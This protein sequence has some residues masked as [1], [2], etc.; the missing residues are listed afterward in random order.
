M[1][2]VIPAILE[3]DWNAIERKLN[4]VKSFAKT[5]HIDVIDGVFA[6]NKTLL[7]PQ[8][9]SVFKEDFIL[10]AHFM[11]DEPVDYLAPFAQAG[12]KRFLGHIERM[13]DQA[14][15]VARAEELGEVGLA[16]DGTTSLDKIEVS[17][18]D[19]DAVLIMTIQAGFSGQSFVAQ[20][21]EKVQK[22]SDQTPFPIEVDGGINEITIIQ[23]KNAGARRF[24]ASS[25]LFGSEN[26]HA[27]YDKLSAACNL[28]S[29]QA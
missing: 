27:Q 15:F 2:E 20:H 5:V 6:Q 28:T 24:I 3:K 7:D 25:F 14:E 21:L 29:A 12:F 9:F 18:N 11:V 10:E 16:L 22:L 26:P 23:A 13:S 8:P 1:Y 19:L 17:L 4:L